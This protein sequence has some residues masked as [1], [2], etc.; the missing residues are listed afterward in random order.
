MD[1]FEVFKGIFDAKVLRVIHVF[2]TNPETEFYLKEISSKS[3]VPIAT[4][5][6]IL[7]KLIKFQLIEEKKV[8]M[9]KLY[10]LGNNEKTK[11][12][13]DSL[14]ISRNA[15]NVFLERIKEISGVDVVI[16]HGEK[17]DVKANL[18][19]IGKNIDISL[20]KSLVGEIK[21]KYNF[22]ILYL[23]LEPDQFEQMSNMGLYSGKKQILYQRY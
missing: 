9:L 8:K 22:S 21:E 16:L 7:Q 19:I 4:T 10:K 2:L 3:R 23:T 18:L 6:R 13:K 15:L 12:L 14:D 20:I 11:I 17:T 1:V 5:F